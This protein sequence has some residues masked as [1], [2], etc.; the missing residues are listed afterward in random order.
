M[1][2][3]L[4]RLL[5]AAL[6]RKN[7]HGQTAGDCVEWLKDY[8][9]FH[10]FKDIGEMGEREVRFYIS[11][12]GFHRNLEAQRQY[13]AIAAI[14][15]FY[16]EVC[17]IDLGDV[18]DVV[19]SNEPK[20]LPLTVRPDEVSRIFC[21]LSGAYRLLAE[22]LYGTGMRVLEGV[23]L[24][25]GDL[26]FKQQ[27][28]LVR[29]IHG[30]VDREVMLPL[31]LATPLKGHLETVQAR[32]EQDM[33]AGFATVYLPP[34]L[35]EE[36]L[37]EQTDLRWH[38]VFPACRLSVDPATKIKRRHHLMAGRFQGKLKE[39]AREADLGKKVDAQT[40]RHSF[41]THL[42]QSGIDI[43]VVQKLLGHVDVAA[44][45]IYAHIAQQDALRVVSPLDR[46]FFGLESDEEQGGRGDS[47]PDLVREEPATY[48]TSKPAFFRYDT[49][50]AE[51]SRALRSRFL[52]VTDRL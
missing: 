22:L 25:V 43:H 19:R 29:T 9:R 21:H 27:R 38:Y 20:D 52:L 37:A 26:D 36:G 15:F 33:K 45:M 41:A 2:D 5:Q 24:R 13:E 40:L 51:S 17:E 1:K 34:A 50:Q 3:E 32:H 8:L 42:L 31:K 46:I 39:A 48:S 49:H 4:V 16:L 28:I 7:I 18:S 44:T 10:H 30:D 12:L 35:A 47:S 23:R 11:H 14:K 6:K